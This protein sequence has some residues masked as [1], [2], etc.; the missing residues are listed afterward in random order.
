MIAKL[1]VAGG[2]TVNTDAQLEGVADRPVGL[3]ADR[4]QRQRLARRAGA[5]RL[6][7]R[8]VG[9]QRGRAPRRRRCCARASRSASRSRRARLLTTALGLHETR[10]NGARVGADVL[11]PGW[12]DYNKRLQ[13]KVYDVTGADPAGRQRA[14]R[15]ARQ[16]LVLGQPRHGRHRSATAP[17]R[18]TR[19]QLRIT[20][21]DGTSAVVRTDNT[22]K[23]APGPIRADDLYRG[24]SYDARRADRRLGLGRL[25][26]LR[27]GPPRPCAPAPQPTLVSQVDPGVT[28]QQQFTPDLGDPAAS[29]A[30]GSS[31]W[32][33][34]SPAGT[35][36]RVT[37]PAGTTVTMRHGEVL[38]PD[39][40]LYTDQPARR[41]RWPPTGSPS[42]APAARRSTSRG[43][44]CTATGTSS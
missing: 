38:N 4:L 20:F 29:R 32:A 3:A 23:Y 17:S 21:T 6:R 36:L 24:E 19:P 43:S 13:Y 9:R 35:G 34:T 16:R 12:T 15:V 10:L 22:W 41:R 42:P 14:R 7:H 5:R 18:G 40:T 39:G 25:Q 27:P 2:P 1:T 44:P 31:T 30:C 37:G 8:A 33:R 11:A 28:V 26:R